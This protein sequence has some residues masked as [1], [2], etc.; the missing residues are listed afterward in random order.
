M[1]QQPQHHHHHRVTS[2]RQG[3]AL[4]RPSWRHTGPVGPGQNRFPNPTTRPVYPHLFSIS[5]T[6][7]A[8][9][10][11]NLNHVDALNLSATCKRLHSQ[12]GL[13]Y[14]KLIFDVQ[15]AADGYITV[16]QL[17]RLVACL[18]HVPY[19]GSAVQ[20]IAI[21]HAGS[22]VGTF[23]VHA[24]RIIAEI[25][26]LTTQ[27]SVFK[28]CG[29]AHFSTPCPEHTVKQLRLLPSLRSIH[30][31]GLESPNGTRLKSALEELQTTRP[32]LQSLKHAVI[33]CDGSPVYWHGALL[34]ETVGLETLDFADK[35][36]TQHNEMATFARSWGRLNTLVLSSTPMAVRSYVDLMH[37][38]LTN[39]IWTNL[40]R[41]SMDM[42]VDEATLFQ[43]VQLLSRS[44]LR[45]LRLVVAA[46]NRFCI[47]GFSP[48]R[49]SDLLQH[50]RYLEELILDEYNMSSYTLLPGS[51]EAWGTHLRAVPSLRILTLPLWFV[52]DDNRVRLMELHST[53]AAFAEEVID[54]YLRKPNF[55]EVRFL[56]T[57]GDTKESFV[58]GGRGRG[59]G[60]GEGDGYG[61]TVMKGY[62]V[63]R[64]QQ[65]V[66]RE[67]ERVGERGS[68]MVKYLGKQ[69]EA[70][71]ADMMFWVPSMLAN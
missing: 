12:N 66:D 3:G 7:L 70:A 10:Y 45:R 68:Y 49:V 57:L 22:V 39:G 55:Q 15:N 14:K 44:P 16:R 13:S 9:I 56:N 33:R 54:T 40:T 25:L 35:Q 8:K 65:Q 28:W 61:G 46:Y 5:A 63:L 43:M 71:E 53:L 38:G 32:N 64:F 52:L 62:K 6:A 50:L 23:A 51:W 2:Y 37:E 26:E 24:D 67:A 69:S 18:R 29:D 27:L 30:L 31:Q 60:Y 21:R 20:T 19:Y 48:E 34:Y 1:S 17:T 58:A 59:D 41:F 47:P 36:Q 4:R 11:E 42:Q